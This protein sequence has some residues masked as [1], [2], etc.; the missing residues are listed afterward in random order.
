METKS[1]RNDIWR[2]LQSPF[3]M[4]I[5]RGFGGRGALPD[6]SSPP[7]RRVVLQKLFKDRAF[8]INSAKLR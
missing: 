7:L 8:L 2:K 3:V 1:E 5:L 6:L 4:F